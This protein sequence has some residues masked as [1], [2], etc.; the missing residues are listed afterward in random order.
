MDIKEFVYFLVFTI[1][2]GF[3]L[4][5]LYIN[6]LRIGEEKQ[7]SRILTITLLV[8]IILIYLNSREVPFSDILRYSALFFVLIFGLYLLLQFLKSFAGYDLGSYHGVVIV[9]TLFVIGYVFYYFNKLI[10]EQN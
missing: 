7:I 6:W 3:A 8:G 9:A 4:S 10:N 1:V 2:M 5:M